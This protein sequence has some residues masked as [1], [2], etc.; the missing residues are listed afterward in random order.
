MFW[1]ARNIR[2]GGKHMSVDMLFLDEKST[3][4]Q[5]TVHAF[6]IPQIQKSS[7]IV[8]EYTQELTLAISTTSEQPSLLTSYKLKVD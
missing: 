4:I 6:R 2:K 7:S 5:G 8:S 1:E 3:L